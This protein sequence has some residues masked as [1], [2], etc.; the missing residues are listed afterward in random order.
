[1]GDKN[2]PL[3][4]TGI[5]YVATQMVLGSVTELQFQH[6]TAQKTAISTTAFHLNSPRKFKVILNF[7]PPHQKIKQFQLTKDRHSALL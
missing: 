2:H 1:M 4:I 7:S 3:S 6:I 5:T